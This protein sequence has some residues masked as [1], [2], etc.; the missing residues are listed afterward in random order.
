MKVNTL[1][2]DWCRGVTPAVASPTLVVGAQRKGSDP[3]LDLC[4]GHL[5]ALLRAFQPHARTKHGL[6][7][8][9]RRRTIRQVATDYNT[10]KVR[11]R[12]RHAVKTPTKRAMHAAR[13]EKALAN[14]EE[15]SALVLAAM[16]NSGQRLGRPQID[17]LAKLPK[18][19]VL[20]SLKLLIQKGLV[21]KYGYK[22]PGAL[23]EKIA[24]AS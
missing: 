18:T 13:H 21:T 11:D 5:G 15:K 2:C 1:A 4:Q 8:Q 6:T 16:P 24:D 14:W 20:K 3:H 7:N 9:N 23:Y 10:K 17:A 19:T 12:V 22:G